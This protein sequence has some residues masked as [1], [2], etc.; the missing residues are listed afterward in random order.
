MGEIRILDIKDYTLSAIK[1]DNNN[2]FVGIKVDFIYTENTSSSDETRFFGI[3]GLNPKAERDATQLYLDLSFDKNIAENDDYM[4]KT[5]TDLFGDKVYTIKTEIQKNNPTF[6]STINKL[7]LEAKKNGANTNIQKSIIQTLLKDGAKPLLVLGLQGYGKTST[8]QDVLHKLQSPK[9][10][11][12]KLADALSISLD[13]ATKLKNFKNNTRVVSINETMNLND[14]Y[15]HITLVAND[16]TGQMSMDYA[17]SSFMEVV[18]G[19]YYGGQKGIIVLDELLDNTELINQTKATIMASGGKYNFT[20][21]YSRE[22]LEIK[23]G[24]VFISG[25]NQ[26]C[27]Y[28]I[29]EVA[30]QADKRFAV[31][32]EAIVVNTQKKA[33]LIDTDKLNNM[34]KYLLSNSILNDVA[35]SKIADRNSAS[36]NNNIVSITNQKYQLI[37]DGYAVLLISKEKAEEIKQLNTDFIIKTSV[38]AMPYMIDSPSLKILATGNVLNNVSQSAL[39]RFSQI[40]ISHISYDELKNNIAILGVGVESNFINKLKKLSADNKAVL[41]Y[42]DIVLKFVK[43]IV[44][45][46]HDGRLLAPQ[47]DTGKEPIYSSE[48][49]SS[50]SLNPRTITSIINNSDTPQE[51]I[52]NFK[53]NSNQILGIENYPDETEA[54]Y[55]QTFNDEVDIILGEALK[56]FCDKYKIENDMTETNKYFEKLL[57]TLPT[58]NL[59]MIEEENQEL[60]NSI[61]IDDEEEP[62][63]EIIKKPGI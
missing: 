9:M 52:D 7:C 63:S 15:G 51:L 37:N 23:S 48:L 13:E 47:Y 2:I 58:L 62:N 24:D 49:L 54:V 56:N 50:I 4:R 26:K 31:D 57:A 16:K 5:I 41:D 36:Y 53:K 1:K 60:D 45:E 32:D 29:C 21:N 14:L 59:N 3:Y 46:Q 11:S 43:K 44:T 33:I 34:Q 19:V 22:F 17:N 55:V 8:I 35:N 6:F 10:T 28:I 27:N 20:P 40:Q 30:L 18:K 38:S 42:V 61:G 39:D 12:E 25:Q